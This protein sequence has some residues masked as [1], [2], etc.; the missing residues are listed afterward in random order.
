MHGEDA[1]TLYMDVIIREAAGEET[2][3]EK[4]VFGTLS[5]M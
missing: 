5:P 2:R 4:D 1:R 3:T